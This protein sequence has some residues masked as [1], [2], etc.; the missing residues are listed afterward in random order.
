MTSGLAAQRR[1]V[2]TN[3]E[4]AA[5]RPKVV[6]FAPHRSDFIGQSRS[7]SPTLQTGLAPYRSENAVKF[8]QEMAASERLQVRI[9]GH[10]SAHLRGLRI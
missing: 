9:L 10:T 1:Q 8:R 4:R 2:S 6:S 7:L 5:R 3:V